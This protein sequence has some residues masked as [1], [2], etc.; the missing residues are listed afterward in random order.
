MNKTILRGKWRRLRGNFK[1]EWGRL[2][3]NDRRLLDGKLDQMVGLF[4]ERYGYTQERAAQAVTRY[5]GSYPAKRLPTPP[6]QMKPWLGIAAVTTLLGIVMVGWLLLSQ[7][8]RAAADFAD[9]N[10][11]EAALEET[12]LDP[13]MA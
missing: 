6:L 4:Q 8:F 3:D 12:L 13:E 7:L 5:L 10:E 2:T 11:V 9:D 1:S